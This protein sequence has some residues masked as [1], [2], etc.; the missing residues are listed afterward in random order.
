MSEESQLKK[1][2]YLIT[3]YENR[4]QLEQ[5]LSLLD[6][7]RNDVYLQIDSKGS[8][9]LDNLTLHKSSLFILPSFPIYWGAFSMIQAELNLLK[10]AAERHYHYYHMI[11][12][13]DLPLVSQD[14]IHNYLENSDLEYVDF[15]PEEKPWAHYKA[16]YYHLFLE[17]KWYLKCV[18]IRGLRYFLVKLQSV[19]GIDRSKK[20][21]EDFYTGS[22]YFS[23]THSLVEYVLTQQLW[24]KNTFHHALACDEVFLQTLIMKSPFKSKLSGSDSGKTKNLRYID[25]I[26]YRK[27][28]P[29][30]FKMSD[31]EEL[32][33]TSKRAF[34]ARKFHRSVDSDIVDRIVERI[35]NNMAL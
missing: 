27:N 1:H 5:L 16:A 21:N 23:I 20:S 28:S 6:N 31:Y 3:A 4:Y 25:W 18:L 32:K 10:A 15:S 34:F 12:G 29:Y 22:T 24:I 33:E 9:R 19:C 13:S 8:L 7:E 11:T 30:T 17:N 35:K 26:R 14:A 2:A